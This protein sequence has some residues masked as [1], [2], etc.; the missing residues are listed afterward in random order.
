MHS[1]NANI[2]T[3]AAGALIVRLN[4]ILYVQRV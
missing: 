3:C 4:D 1:I 2:M